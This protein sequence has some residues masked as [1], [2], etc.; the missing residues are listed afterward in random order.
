MRAF[1]IDN[2]EH[3]N[4]ADRRQSSPTVFA[5][6]VLATIGDDI[7]PA[8]DTHMSKSRVGRITEAISHSHSLGGPACRHGPSTGPNRRELLLG[9]SALGVLGF[10]TRSFANDKMATTISD[11][12]ASNHILSSQGVLDSYGH[13][14]ARSPVR[15]DRFLL[16]RSL[17]PGSVTSEDIL[18]FD[19]DGTVVGGT[20]N[21]RY[22]ERFI[23]WAIYRARPD[24]MAIV[25]SHSPTSIAFS[26]SKVPLRAVTHFGAFIGDHAAV[27][28]ADPDGKTPTLLIAN[29]A[30]GTRLAAALGDQQ[31]I[32][33]RG[34][35]DVIVGPSI[36]TATTRALNA[37]KNAKVLL[38]GYRLS[39]EI[40]ALTKDE[41]NALTKLETSDQEQRE[42]TTLKKSV[43]GR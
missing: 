8:E 17:A 7:A 33:I 21:R 18:E 20:A 22:L 9:L 37:A 34:H 16:S 40:T 29:N 15:A 3:S 36:R 4:R 19:L 32:L 26:I 5:E 31:M 35:G 28:E 2:V 11:L 25:H 43:G 39:A 27:F 30:L 42:W 12:V 23:H 41:D 38:D 1:G 6:T 10:S 13:V 24:V 14:S